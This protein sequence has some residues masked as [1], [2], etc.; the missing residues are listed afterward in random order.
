M[1]RSV[2]P[3]FVNSTV[4]NNI[5]KSNQMTMKNSVYFFFIPSSFLLFSFF[6][7]CQMKDKDCKKAFDH[8]LS[9]YCSYQVY[10][11]K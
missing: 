3:E 6:F 7:P 5:D 11:K 1:G 10:E 2:E 8:L 9:S 4:N